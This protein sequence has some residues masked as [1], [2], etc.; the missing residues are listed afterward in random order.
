MPE[1]ETKIAAWR[2]RMTAALPGRTDAVRELEE[3]L[4]DHCAELTA[5]GLAPAEAWAQAERRLGETASVAREF[6]RLAAPWWCGAQAG[7][8]RT[9]AYASGALGLAAFM[10]YSLVAGWGFLRLLDGRALPV[11]VDLRWAE[12]WQTLAVVLA[13]A[14][15][16]AIRASGR[17]L[18]RP[19]GHDLRGVIAFYLLAV[20]MLAGGATDGLK[21]AYGLKVTVVLLMLAG[22]VIVWRKLGPCRREWLEAGS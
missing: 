11:P 17:F 2:A 4:R 22:I 5:R 21:I 8:A 13:V 16:L 14:S 20:W 1:L 9:L 10:F 6:D 15:A 19:N 7:V 12:F 18:A 3:H